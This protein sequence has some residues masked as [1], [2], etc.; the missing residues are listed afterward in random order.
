MIAKAIANNS[1]ISNNITTGRI[2]LQ[3]YAFMLLYTS[4][5]VSQIQH[6]NS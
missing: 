4:I 6:L 5:L 2:L 1:Y 3:L